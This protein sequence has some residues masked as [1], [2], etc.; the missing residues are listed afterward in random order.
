MSNKKKF[1]KNI[2]KK[3][4]KMYAAAKLNPNTESRLLFVSGKYGFSVIRM[5]EVPGSGQSFVDSAEVVMNKTVARAISTGNTNNRPGIGS[6][7]TRMYDGQ[8]LANSY[9]AKRDVIPS[10]VDYA[11]MQGID[12]DEAADR[13]RD[14]YVD[15][16]D[17]RK[18]TIMQTN[19]G[20]IG[21]DIKRLYDKG[22]EERTKL[23][24]ELNEAHEKAAKDFE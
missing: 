11:K 5:D 10:S 1:E 9:D 13:Q 2:S 8:S 19:A 15:H 17:G 3:L 12:L 20:H 14:N 6:I 7:K 22:I 4:K 16:P 18:A 24:H 21:L 23:K